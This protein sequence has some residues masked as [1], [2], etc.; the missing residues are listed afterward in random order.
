V[1]RSGRE[2][3]RTNCLRDMLYLRS[4]LFI[5]WNYRHTF[6]LVVLLTG[7]GSGL[8]QAA[9]FVLTKGSSSWLLSGWRQ[10]HSRRRAWFANYFMAAGRWSRVMAEFGGGAFEYGVEV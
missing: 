7:L 8:V 4:V 2:D 3:E 6:W 9:G 1:W 10:E 5:R